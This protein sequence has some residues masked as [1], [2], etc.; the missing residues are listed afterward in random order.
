MREVEEGVA[1]HREENGINEWKIENTNAIN[2]YKILKMMVA[3]LDAS[4]V[5]SS[6]TRPSKNPTIEGHIDRDDVEK[7]LYAQRRAH[8]ITGVGTGLARS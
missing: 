7:W 2:K 4:R 3:F 5:A 8:D 1:K 6:T